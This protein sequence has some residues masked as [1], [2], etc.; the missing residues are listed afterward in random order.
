LEL[1]GGEEKEEEEGVEVEGK[2]LEVY[3]VE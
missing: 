2:V 1:K 3:V